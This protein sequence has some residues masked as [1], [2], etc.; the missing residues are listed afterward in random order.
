MRILIAEDDHVNRMVLRLILHE[1]GYQPSIVENG[2]QAVRS[3]KDGKYDV[4][5]MDVQMP[6]MNGIAATE[7]IRRLI[8]DAIRP[9]IVALS[10][11]DTEEKKK[12]CLQ[13]GMNDFLEKPISVT[14]IRH[15]L[16][17]ARTALYPEDKVTL[18]GRKRVSFRSEDS[19]LF[20]DG[21]QATAISFDSIPEG[22]ELIDLDEL[23]DRCCGQKK[24]AAQLAQVFFEH[25]F[26]DVQA[27]QA[28]FDHGMTDVLVRLTHRLK[29]SVVILGAD[30][31]RKCLQELETIARRNRPED[32]QR[33][34]D[35]LDRIRAL[36]YGMKQYLDTT[37][38]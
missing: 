15:S 20:P 30:H 19:P 33:T 16:A 35:L 34:R 14:A 29:G 1:L 6:E 7:E 13:A 12:S 9:W 25:F 28:A 8:P 2:H 5:L 22:S 17:A 3:V 24:N 27:M 4:V 10:A 37:L 21:G 31:L 23:M 38:K 26:T 36:G 32:R 11:D 18:H